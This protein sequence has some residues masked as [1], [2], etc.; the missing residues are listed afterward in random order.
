VNGDQET[1][2]QIDAARKFGVSDRTL[3]RWEKRGLIKGTRVI[4]L[5]FYPLSDLRKLTGAKA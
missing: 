5:K 3:R 2:K 1:I 4:G